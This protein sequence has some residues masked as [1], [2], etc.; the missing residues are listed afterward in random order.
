[1]QFLPTFVDRNKTAH[2]VY[3][4]A[5]QVKGCESYTRGIWKADEEPMKRYREEE[6]W[7]AKGNDGLRGARKSDEPCIKF[8]TG[9]GCTEGNLCPRAHEYFEETNRCYTC[10]AKGHISRNC[11]MPQGDYLRNKVKEESGRYRYRREVTQNPQRSKWPEVHE[12]KAKVTSPSRPQTP[13]QEISTTPKSQTSQQEREEEFLRIY[14]QE[15]NPHMR[16]LMMK[17]N[18]QVLTAEEMQAISRQIKA[19]RMQQVR[20]L[21][22]NEFAREEVQEVITGV[23]RVIASKTGKPKPS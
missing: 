23:P 11:N 14:N 5:C 8:I 10:G 3:H 6:H 7:P 2:A 13:Q 9:V 22:E 12:A 4:Q 1:M 21:V 19:D 20:I 16:K 15:T 17:H 18:E